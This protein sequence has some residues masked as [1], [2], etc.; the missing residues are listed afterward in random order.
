MVGSCDIKLTLYAAWLELRTENF[1]PV[2]FDYV[3]RQCE[4]GP[5]IFTKSYVIQR[6][7]RA[8]NCS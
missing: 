8:L 5:K 1:R 6:L 2:R 4:P 3:T 7:E